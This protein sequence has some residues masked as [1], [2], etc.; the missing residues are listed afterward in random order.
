MTDTTGY[1]AEG[2]INFKTKKMIYTSLASG[3]LEL[4][5]MN[6]DGSGKKR[7][8]NT[9]GY[10]GGRGFFARRQANG[11]ARLSSRYAREDRGNDR[12]LL[13][14]NLTTPMKMELFVANADGSIPPNRSPIS[15]APASRPRLLRI[16]QK[17]LFCIEQEQMRF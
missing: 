16:N 6:E 13:K 4:W 15:D 7:I 9:E 10:D 14:D 11:M 1:D 12:E 17:I 3:D 5:T 2:T 8:T